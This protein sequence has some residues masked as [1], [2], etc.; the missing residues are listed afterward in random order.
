VKGEAQAA[1]RKAIR[2]SFV[3]RF[4]LVAYL[5]AGL[6]AASDVAA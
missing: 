3:D 6:T 4:R 2:E 5:A 1:I